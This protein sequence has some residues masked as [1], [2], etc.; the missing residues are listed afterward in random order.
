M[1]KQVPDICKTLAREARLRRKEIDKTQAEIA[2]ALG[3]SV[4][5]VSR[6]ERVAIAPSLET[7]EGLARVLGVPPSQLLG[8]KPALPSSRNQRLTRIVDRLVDLD[9]DHLAQ[10]ERVLAAL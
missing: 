8:G 9:D 4:D 7:L 6:I 3:L 10:V 2:D 5:M 1:A